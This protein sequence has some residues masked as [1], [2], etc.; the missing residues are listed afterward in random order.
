MAAA[1]PV[2]VSTGAGASYLI[3]NG[4]TGLT[5]P[6][7]DDVALAD[8]LNSIAA[9]RQ[10]LPALGQAARASLDKRLSPAACTARYE[11]LATQAQQASNRAFTALRTDSAA[12]ILLPLIDSLIQP[13]KLPQRSGRE[14]LGALTRK[15]GQRLGVDPQS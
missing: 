12:G 15:I 2:L 10:R 14:L 6:V 9:K 11:E 4:T 3:E 1:K 8:L 13:G 7:D 5:F